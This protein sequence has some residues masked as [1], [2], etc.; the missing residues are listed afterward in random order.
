MIGAH[1][2][3]TRRRN[4]NNSIKRMKTIITILVTSVL[5]TATS[6]NLVAQP[7]YSNWSQ[8]VNLGP[9]INTAFN[10]QH[11][12][13]SKDGLSL[14]ITSNRSGGQGAD[15]LWV[16]Q[17]ASVDDAWGPPQNLGPVINTTAVE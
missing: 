2:T 1:T 7:K 17:R 16:S 3:A 9:V 5:A 4:T 11:P 12:A 13:L 8:P 15:D 6:F 10:D 14:Y